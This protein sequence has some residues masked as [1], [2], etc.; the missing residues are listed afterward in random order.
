MPGE[1][2]TIGAVGV[3]PVGTILATALSRAGANIIVADLPSRNDQ[4]Q[5][6][7]LVMRWNEELLKE[8]AKTVDSISAMEEFHPDVIF[9]ATK[10][11]IL[12]KVMPSVAEAVKGDCIVLSV[13]NGI[14][15]EDFIAKYVNPDRVSRMVVNYAGG[16]DEHGNV[17][18][19]WFNPPNFL[20]PLGDKVDPKLERIVE[21]LNSVGLKSELVDS[22][23][24]KSCAYLKTTLNSALMPICGV[25]GLTMKEA[26]TG[27]ATRRLAGDLLRE[28]FSVAEKLG[29]SYGENIWETC[30][31]YLDKGGDHHP[32]MTTDLQCKRATEIEF[33]NGK[34]LEIGMKFKDLDM[35]VN[36][37]MV[38]MIMSMEVRNGTRDPGNF[39]EYLV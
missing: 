26:M 27:K 17:K 38:S 12:E 8:P 24:I 11:C 29:Y 22:K 16:I 35:E 25:M 21:M 18:V 3:G 23:G 5:N 20:G 37:V 19:N 31:G 32:S 1:K 15:T 28:G 13:H 10:A 33:I 4:I 6:F 30:M 2:L 39:P 34:I 14:G 36:R 7:G 9:I